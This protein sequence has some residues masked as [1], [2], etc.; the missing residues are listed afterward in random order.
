MY[1]SHC[2]RKIKSTV[3]QKYRNQNFSN[4]AQK[5]KTL[6][7]IYTATIITIKRIDPQKPE[8]KY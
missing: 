5:R 6:K 2:R 4:E 7:N 1:I 3:L 8:E